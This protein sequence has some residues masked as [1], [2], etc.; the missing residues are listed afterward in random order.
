[1]TISRQK[2]KTGILISEMIDLQVS[3]CNLLFPNQYY[4]LDSSIS[5][6]SIN[7]QHDKKKKII[8]KDKMHKIRGK[9]SSKINQMRQTNWRR[10]R[11]KINEQG[12]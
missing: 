12:R 3:T 5:K 8:I 6:S 2:K 1:M 11:N 9:I 10:I 4:N 7:H